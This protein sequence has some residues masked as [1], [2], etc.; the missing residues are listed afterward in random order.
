MGNDQ[1]PTAPGRT[2]P[3][4]FRQ[5]LAALLVAIAVLMPALP[6]L[7]D[8]RLVL[9]PRQFEQDKT[10]AGA[11]LC[12]WSLFLA[13][14]AGTLACGLTRRPSDDAIDDAI[15]AI[16]DFILAH[17]SLHPTREMLDDFKRRGAELLRSRLSLTSPACQGGNLRRFRNLSPAQI[18]ATT[19]ALLAV[20]REPVMNPC[21]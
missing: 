6:V 20:P 12:S 3:I 11:V 15:V 4:C 13:V 16:D 7:A 21:P 14:Q 18:R 5:G 1:G 2:R 8:D 10:G 17:S 19:K 9:G